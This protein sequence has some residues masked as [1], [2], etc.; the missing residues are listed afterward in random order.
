MKIRGLLV[1][2]G[3]GENRTL[4]QTS[5]QKAFYMYSFCLDFRQNSLAKN[6]HYLLNFINVRADLKF[7]HS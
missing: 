6:S 2:C 5:H 1:F 3:V 4:V 7:Y